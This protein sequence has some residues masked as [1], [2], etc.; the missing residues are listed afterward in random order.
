[1]AI[2][3]KVAFQNRALELNISQANIDALNTAGKSSYAT[4]AYCCTFQPG[5]AD[6][7]P[8]TDFLVNTV[9]VDNSAATAAK[10]RRLFFEAHEV[11]CRPFRIK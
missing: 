3:S 6:D 11:P 2:D 4:F 9:G 8:L 7:T 10:F 1:M 5:Q